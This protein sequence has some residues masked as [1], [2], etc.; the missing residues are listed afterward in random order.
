MKRLL[1][2][3]A[4]ALVIGLCGLTLTNAPVNAQ[5]A[6]WHEGPS[7]GACHCQEGQECWSKGSRIFA[8]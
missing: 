5:H 2:N 4:A 7:C 3:V 8:T 6:E 1:V